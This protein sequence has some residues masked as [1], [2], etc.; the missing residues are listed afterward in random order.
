[1]LFTLFQLLKL[2]VRAVLWKYYQ[3]KDGSCAVKFYVHDGKKQQFV[4][5]KLHAHPKDWDGNLGRFKRTVPHWRRLNSLLEQE[6]NKLLGQL[7]GAD[8]SLLE[9]VAEYI[10][11]CKQGIHQWTFNTWRQYITH[12]DKLKAFCYAT[13]R[14]DLRFAEIDLAFYKQFVGYL[15]ECG[16]GI[17]GTDKQVK[18][19]RKFLR[20][21]YDR[22]LHTNRIF[23]NPLF[24][25]LKYKAPPKIYLTE[26]EI[27]QFA[28]TALPDFVLSREQDR[29]MVSYY[30][31]LRHGDSVKLNKG[32]FF[33]QDGRMY[34]RNQAE[35]TGS[36]SIVPVHPTALDILQ[37]REF[38]LS[39][40]TNQESN[41][42]LKMIAARAEINDLHEGQPKWSFV[43][44]HTARR[45]AATN[46]FLRSTPLNEIMQLGGWKEGKTLKQYLLAGGIELAKT[47]ANRDF[48][49]F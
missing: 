11:E 12:L 35:K 10:E 21:S 37:R 16:L 48:F 47:S 14:D 24:A 23:E 4:T 19:L 25:R 49:N 2:T 39:G 1:M 30:L 31:L 13:E 15:R 36:V 3:R 44:T 40:D 9:F 34:F 38:D 27:Q 28:R 42:K 17:P 33:T 5:T 6:Q 41:R 18:H 32:M 20:L 45:S 22:G 8:D 29:F 26:D 46:L 7:I 43:T